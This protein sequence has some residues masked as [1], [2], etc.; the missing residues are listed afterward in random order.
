MLTYADVCV[1][2]IGGVPHSD[3][4]RQLGRRDEVLAQY[5]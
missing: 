3:R 4:E 1:A 2:S 5:S